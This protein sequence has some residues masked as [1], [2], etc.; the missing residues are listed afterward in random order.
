M[1]LLIELCAAGRKM[2]KVIIKFCERLV[3]TLGIRDEDLVL[4]GVSRLRYVITAN[5]L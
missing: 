4:F 2:C 5:V 1:K 3:L